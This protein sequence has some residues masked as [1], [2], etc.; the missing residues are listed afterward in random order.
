MSLSFQVRLLDLTWYFLV[1][2]SCCVFVCT[3]FNVNF[4]CIKTLLNL[5]LVVV[6]TLKYDDF[7]TQNVADFIITDQILKSHQDVWFTFPQ[8]KV[9]K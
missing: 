7:L 8:N 5:S 4:C 6:D 3:I 2:G 1:R 9:K